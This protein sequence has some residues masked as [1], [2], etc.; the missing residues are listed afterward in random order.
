MVIDVRVTVA[1]ESETLKKFAL[2][3]FFE[4]GLP[5]LYAE[6]PFFLLFRLR[7]LLLFLFAIHLV[8][9]ILED[10]RVFLELGLLQSRV[11]EGHLLLFLFVGPGL[12][13]M[14]HQ[15][16][17]VVKFDRIVVGGGG[18]DL[19]AARQGQALNWKMLILFMLSNHT[20]QLIRL[21]GEGPDE[22]V[23]GAS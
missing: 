23:F 21:E 4:F 13:P 22:T 17:Y 14:P 10:V 8:A 7:L 12:R 20:E 19:S 16:I 6:V 5:L 3:L 11:L 9:V 18:Q 15:L 1:A 2:S